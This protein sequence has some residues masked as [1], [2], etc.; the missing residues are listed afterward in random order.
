MEFRRLGCGM[1]VF[2]PWQPFCEPDIPCV[3]DIVDQSV[4][5]PDFLI[6]YLI[7]IFETF[8]QIWFPAHA[9]NDRFVAF[10]EGDAGG[11]DFV[12]S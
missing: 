4:A 10:R 11:R 12:R 7:Q 3:E 1:G 9:V 5:R 2:A 6:E 8:C